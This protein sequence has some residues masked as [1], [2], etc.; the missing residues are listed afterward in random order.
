[1]LGSQETSILEEKV[2]LIMIKISILI[3]ANSFFL[4]ASDIVQ[5]SRGVSIVRYSIFLS[6]LLSRALLGPRFSIFVSRFDY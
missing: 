4:L 1:M 5:M 3:F 2:K 6:A